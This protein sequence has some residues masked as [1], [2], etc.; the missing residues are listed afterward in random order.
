MKDECGVF[1]VFGHLEASELCYLGLYALQHR[2]QES[3]GI[4]SSD[5]GDF[6][7]VKDMG[8]VGEV[9]DA[10]RLESLKGTAAIG[11]VRYSTTGSSHA[12]NIQPLYA[13]TGQGKLAIA[14][15]GNLTNAGHL[16]TQLKQ[17]G[18]L[19]QSTVDTEVLLHIWCSRPAWLSATGPGKKRRCLDFS[20]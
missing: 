5:N 1:G 16:H 19:F 10:N 4:I 9:F 11:H 15:N 14:H 12:H 20:F 18:A 17:D 3:A 6:Y 7:V 2:G 13:K 8:L